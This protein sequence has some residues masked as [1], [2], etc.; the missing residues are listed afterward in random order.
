SERLTEED[1]RLLTI[2][3]SEVERLDELVNTMLDIGRPKEPRPLATDLNSL[4][5]DVVE[6]VRRGGSSTA[7]LEV[8]LPS[9]Q[10]IAWVD[11]DQTRQV[12]WNLLKNAIQASS[13]G[14]TVTVLVDSFNERAAFEVHDQGE[15]IDGEKS[16]QLF[17]MFYSGRTHGVG[18]G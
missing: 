13:P 2:V 3:V 17:E 12:L 5:S 4:V 8:V 6:M 9:E 15:G 16:S 7:K 11:P 18:L 14:D 10:V 1:R